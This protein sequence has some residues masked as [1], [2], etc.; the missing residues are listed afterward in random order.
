MLSRKGSRMSLTYQFELIVY[1]K[2]V[3]PTT[4]SS[5][6]TAHTSLLI[7]KGYVRSVSQINAAPVPIVLSIDI[8]R[9]VNLG[10]R[11]HT[12]TAHKNHL[13]KFVALL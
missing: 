2:N 8:V 9:N 1:S 6:G 7:V 10:A 4:H 12:Y 5:N 11:R 3:G 13:Q